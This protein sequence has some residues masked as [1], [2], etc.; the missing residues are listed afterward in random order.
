MHT[1]CIC[2]YCAYAAVYLKLHCI[3]YAVLCVRA[4]DTVCVYESA[5]NVE[6][7]GDDYADIGASWEEGLNLF[8][9][10]CLDFNFHSASPV[11]WQLY[12]SMYC[13]HA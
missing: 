5:M 8:F 4:Q 13:T 9:A 12:T 6:R 3:H 10:R 7:E 1:A 2:T 11:L